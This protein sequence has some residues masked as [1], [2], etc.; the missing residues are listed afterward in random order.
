[1]I[2]LIPDAMPELPV[3]RAAVQE[4]GTPR[5]GRIVLV[6]MLNHLELIGRL[7]GFSWARDQGWL[8]ASDEQVQVAIN[9]KSGGIRYSLRPLAEEPGGNMVSSA[10]RLEEIAREFLVHLGRPSEPLSLERITHLHAQTSTV[11]GELSNVATLDAGLIFRRSVDELPVIGPGG[12]AMVRI[13][14]DEKVVGGREVCRPIVGRGPMLDLRSPENAIEVLL[15]RLEARGLDGEVRVRSA[16][17]GYEERGIE[18]LQRGL[19]PSYAFQVEKMGEAV[20][21]K[22]VEVISALLPSVA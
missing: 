14:T 8:T 19:E 6:S 4:L 5:V 16:L 13:G 10:A 20:D 21:Y 9:A 11:D 7:S 3:A 17:F 15:E 12:F 22:T 18:E 2:T 1:M